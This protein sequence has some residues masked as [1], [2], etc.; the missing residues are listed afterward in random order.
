M[1]GEREDWALLD[2]REERHKKSCDII[3]RRRAAP[4]SSDQQQA[5]RVTAV[6]ARVRQLSRYLSDLVN[7]HSSPNDWLGLFYGYD[8]VAT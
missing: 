7:F 4:L 5:L 3:S 1:K 8:S 2:V 6:V